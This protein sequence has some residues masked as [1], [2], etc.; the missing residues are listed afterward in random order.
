MHDSPAISAKNSTSVSKEKQKGNSSFFQPI[1]QPKL[2]INQPN[3]I[4]EQE[5][6]AVAEKVMRMP[7]SKTEPLFFQPQPLPVTPL[8]RKCAACE[9]EE[10]LQRME[11]EEEEPVQL[12]PTRE[13]D[14]QRKCSHCEEEEEK[15]QMKG[16]PTA[17]RGMTAPS[18]VHSVINSGG[19]S[20]DKST[21]SF[22]ESRF[23]YDFG[24]VQ[25][26]NDSLAHKSSKDI[27]ALAYTHRNH[28]VF[29]A[30]QYQPNTNSGKQLLAHEL[31]HVVQQE[32]IS[33][34]IQRKINTQAE[35]VLSK[36][37]ERFSIAELDEGK[38]ETFSS[39]PDQNQPNDINAKNTSP[40]LSIEDVTTKPIDIKLPD[41]VS[42]DPLSSQVAGSPISDQEPEFI[43]SHGKKPSIFTSEVDDTDRLKEQISSTPDGEIIEAFNFEVMLAKDD[44]ILIADSFCND[45]EA[46]RT[47]TLEAVNNFVTDKLNTI[48]QYFGL[49]QLDLIQQA[50]FKRNELEEERA[51]GKKMLH[52]NFTTQFNSN[53]KNYTER[54]TELQTKATLQN[55]DILSYS[56]SKAA[57]VEANTKINVSIILKTGKSIAKNYE[58]DYNSEEIF[59]MAMDSAFD[60]SNDMKTAGAQTA[61]ALRKDGV[62]VSGKINE[63][64]FRTQRGLDDMYVH[65]QAGLFSLYEESKRQIDD[66]VNKAQVKVDEVYLYVLNQIPT[67]KGLTVSSIKLLYERFIQ[68]FTSSNIKLQKVIKEAGVQQ[69]QYLQLSAHNF[70]VAAE[71]GRSTGDRLENYLSRGAIELHEMN[72]QFKTTFDTYGPV[73][74]DLSD[75]SKDLLI[76][77]IDNLYNKGIDQTGLLLNSTDVSVSQMIGGVIFSDFEINRK[78]NESF[79]K[80]N[81]AFDINSRNITSRT[82]P[83]F[84]KIVVEAKSGIDEKVNKITDAQTKQIEVFREKVEEEAEDMS[85]S[86]ALSEALNFVGNAIVSIVTAIAG[87]VWGVFKAILKLIVGLVLLIVAIV[88]AIALIIVAVI[89]IFILLVVFLGAEL[90]L[91]IAAIVGLV[92]LC[93]VALA[94]VVFI[95]YGIV[96]TIVSVVKNIYK[97]CTDD[98]LSTFERSSL[99]G[100][101]LT[102]IFLLLL[103][104]KGKAKAPPLLEGKSARGLIGAGEE[105]AVALPGK[106]PK[107]LEAPKIESPTIESPVIEAPKAE[108]PTVESPIIEAPKAEAPAVESPIIEAPKAE[109]PA[110]ESPIIE[111]PK[112]EAP[113]MESPIIEPPKTEATAM[114]SPISEAPKTEAPTMESPVGEAPKGQTP[115][116]EPAKAKAPSDKFT[117]LRDAAKD[118]Y[119]DASNNA[120]RQKMEYQNL[121]RDPNRKPGWRQKVEEKKEMW[122]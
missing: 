2:T 86:N 93:I 19:R 14:V 51:N 24:N 49:Q 40:G 56:E 34:S 38:R 89:A 21:R 121:L 72:S 42:Q 32:K 28:V 48:D 39:L 83:Q 110:V 82:L 61:A 3:D 103:P 122:E 50:L 10:H 44:A 43:F 64:V 76:Q 6:D 114:E 120:R 33:P 37:D 71:D 4:Y 99:I 101:S 13:F 106:G 95:V 8:Q 52:E 108:I 79:I 113:A 46:S 22:M 90:A 94:A 62:A 58:D 29:G 63:L 35:P 9:S 41:N 53:F 47:T 57:L 30:G 115:L 26:H 88:V 105:A 73:F 117:D 84:D 104:F 1:V 69:A 98:S 59:N 18:I 109:A 17:G 78:A 23:G 77:G 118:R 27:N 100:E 11:D 70:L 60:A 54:K 102:D 116:A 92:L 74:L 112:A 91:A 65:T 67:L 25:I 68:I 85:Y 5:A 96:M 7:D 36:S 80:E 87:F 81:V 16:E 15:V 66:T 20:L 45:L 111:A 75:S 55:L 31:A 12:K 119:I 107:L 97:A